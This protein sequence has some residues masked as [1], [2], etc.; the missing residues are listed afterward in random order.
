[1]LYSVA[2]SQVAGGGGRNIAMLPVRQTGSPPRI[3]PVADMLP[4]SSRTAD[5]S[6]GSSADYKPAGHTGCKPMSPFAVSFFL[7]NLLP[8][9][10]QYVSKQFKNHI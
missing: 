10:V 9:F 6:P 5:A 8:N 7:H 2:A 1:M 4:V 3:R